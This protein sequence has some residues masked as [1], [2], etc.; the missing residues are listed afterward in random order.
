M[1]LETAFGLVL[2]ELRKRQG[3]SQ[4]KLAQETDLK[5]TDT[6]LRERGVTFQADPHLIH[7][8]QDGTEEWM[9][10][11]ADPDG[12]TMALMSRVPPA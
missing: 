11:F 12:N 5:R 4:D 3:L 10:F 1:E 8:H 7:R 6:S 9:A 2:R